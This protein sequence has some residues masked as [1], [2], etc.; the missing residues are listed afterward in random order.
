MRMYMCIWAVSHLCVIV[1]CCIVDSLLVRGVMR[2]S[3]HDIAAVFTASQPLLHWAYTHE[4]LRNKVVNNWVWWTYCNSKYDTWLFMYISLT[5]CVLWSEN[6][7]LHFL[8][9]VATPVDGVYE[10]L[11]E[12]AS[13]AGWVD[14]SVSTIAGWYIS[15]WEHERLSTARQVHY[16]V[17]RYI[18]SDDNDQVISIW[19]YCHTMIPVLTIVSIDS[20]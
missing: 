5:L 1:C 18:F 10:W 16:R 15:E 4:P 12:A 3:D 6:E 13:R 9:V 11:Y 8:F 19:R 17:G 7:L 2:L 14:S 20:T